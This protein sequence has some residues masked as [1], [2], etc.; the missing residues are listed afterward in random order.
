MEGER[1]KS[2]VVDCRGSIAQAYLFSE[3]TVDTSSLAEARPA[4]IQ[5]G[6]LIK[7]TARGL[8][9]GLQS[10]DQIVTCRRQYQSMAFLH[11]PTCDCIV[12]KSSR[13]AAHLQG[14]PRDG[15]AQSRTL[16]LQTLRGERRCVVPD[17]FATS[18][19]L[20]GRSSTPLDSPLRRTCMCD[21]VAPTHALSH[22]LPDNPKSLE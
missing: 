13:S 12:G 9:K 6:S 5:K 2:H 15:G 7:Y 20:E 16:Q 22:L 3:R 19:E 18:E 14:P 11:C 17:G 4:A 21:C 10:C 8:L 1:G